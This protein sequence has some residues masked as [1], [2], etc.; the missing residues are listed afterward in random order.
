MTQE[1][2]FKNLVEYSA[3]QFVKAMVENKLVDD[4]KFGSGNAKFMISEFT[5]TIEIED[6]PEIRR[7]LG[8]IP[9]TG[10]LLINS[11]YFASWDKMKDTNNKD[12]SSKDFRLLQKSLFHEFFHMLQTKG[13]GK[14]ESSALDE[15]AAS[16]AEQ[17][18]WTTYLKNVGENIPVG[19]SVPVSYPE[20]VMHAERIFRNLGINKSDFIMSTTALD[21]GQYTSIN[22]KFKEHGLGYYTDFIKP[23]DE[24]LFCMQMEQQEECQQKQSELETRI[25]KAHAKLNTVNAAL[26]AKH[27]DPN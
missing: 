22:K 15:I 21:D 11:A 13:L 5:K 9:E 7:I 27:K 26:N 17:M 3:E 6:N 18:T 12:Y 20:L 4:D 23:L 2:H 24:I 8:V 14:A 10:T 25:S 1:E 16:L 19:A